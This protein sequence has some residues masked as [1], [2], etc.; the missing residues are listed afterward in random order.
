MELKDVPISKAKQRPMDT[1]L[2]DCC[3]NARMRVV[4]E[5]PSRAQC[6]VDLCIRHATNTM[7][8]I[9]RWLDDTWEP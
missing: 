5:C 3:S 4:V 8:F 2:Y 1:P 6:G 7:N 9:L